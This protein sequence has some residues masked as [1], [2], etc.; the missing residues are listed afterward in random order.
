LID[1]RDQIATMKFYHLI[2]I[3][4]AIYLQN[5]GNEVSADIGPPPPLYPEN[6][7][8]HNQI[9]CYDNYECNDLEIDPRHPHPNT[10]VC[11]NVRNTHATGDHK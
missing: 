1:Y 10:G 8:A 6:C 3:F 11:K 2:S 9:P 4:I 7:Q 5:I